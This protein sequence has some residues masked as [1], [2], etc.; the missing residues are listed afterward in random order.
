MIEIR[1]QKYSKL[2][3]YV[4][5]RPKKEKSARRRSKRG[6]GSLKRIYKFSL[7]ISLKHHQL[8]KILEQNTESC[9]FISFLTRNSENRQKA[10]GRED[11]LL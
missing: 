5:F 2:E 9:T 11:E 1:G 7:N 3:I 4:I 6:P 10:L 8:F